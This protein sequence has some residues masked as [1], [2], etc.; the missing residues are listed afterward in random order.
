[1]K[2]WSF[3]LAAA[4]LAVLL[5]AC[6]GRID[7]AYESGYHSGYSEG[8]D[9]GFEDGYDDCYYDRP[10]AASFIYDAATAA[11]GYVFDKTGMSA[12]DAFWNI[13]QYLHPDP[14]EDS[15]SWQEYMDSIDAIEWYYNYFYAQIY[16]DEYEYYYGG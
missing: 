3:V 7:Q 14:K 11:E 8:Y 12:E 4:S 9:A 13:N 10:D 1:M 5:T 6:T 15:V 2:K 16:R